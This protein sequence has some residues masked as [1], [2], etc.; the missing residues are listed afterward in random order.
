M[1]AEDF[2]VDDG[3]DWEVLEDVVEHVPN[4]P[5]LTWDVA[6]IEAIA[7][8]AKTVEL[9]DVGAFVISAEHEKVFPVEDLVTEEEANCLEALKA[10][11]NVISEEEI[12]GF[13]W[14]LADIKDAK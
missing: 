5:L 3:G 4:C 9:V 7:V 13:W 6:R 1:D 11:V 8:I 2:V 14:I 12:V 10:A